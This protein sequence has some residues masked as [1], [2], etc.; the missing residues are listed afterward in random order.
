MCGR[1]TLRKGLS[2]IAEK[3]GDY[4]L[5]SAPEDIAEEVPRYNIAPTQ[6]NLVLRKSFENPELLQ[7]ARLRWGLVPSW[8][9]TP[10]TQTP[11]INARSE[12]VAEKPS[13]RAAFQRRRCLVPADGFYE[14]KKHK[15][16]N[17]PYFFS[18]ADESVFLM[19]G[20]WETWVGEH[21]QQFDSFTILTTHAN[22]LMAKYHERMPVILDGDRIAQW[23]ETDVP[24]LSPAD[25]HELFAP[26]ESDHM[27]CRPANPI[28]NNNRSDGPACLEAP[29]SNPL[30]QL[31]LGL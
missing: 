27:V 14:W 7:I 12:T 29:A 18:L 13:F 16:A 6:K 22:A 15:G 17:L 28:V 24:K 31:D 2:S 21:N 20:I 30:S 10:Q 4:A 8:S 9:K 5:E 1:Y 11:M 25:Q 19:A 3:L 26:V 23:L